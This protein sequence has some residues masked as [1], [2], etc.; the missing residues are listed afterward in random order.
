MTFDL[1]ASMQRLLA[2]DS[3]AAYP[4]SFEQC[5]K[6]RERKGKAEGFFFFF[7]FFFFNLFLKNTPMH[8]L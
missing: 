1:L 7:F 2:D 8:S 5:T 6:E 3:A 4:I